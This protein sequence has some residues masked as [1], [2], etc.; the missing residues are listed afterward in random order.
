MHI[1]PDEI[2]Y[3]QWEFVTINATLVFTW[4]IRAAVRVWCLAGDA[5]SLD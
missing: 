4:A 3:W 5:Q 2:V 1:S